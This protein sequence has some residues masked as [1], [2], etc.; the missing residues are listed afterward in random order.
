MALKLIVAVAIA[1]LYVLLDRGLAPFLGKRSPATI[2][3]WAAGLLLLTFAVR[4]N[5][6]FRLPEG[7][8][9]VIGLFS[10]VLAVNLLIARY[11]GYRPAG[12]LNRFNFAVVYPVF[13]EIAFRGLILPLLAE[14]AF[15]AKT[16]RIPGIGELNG[17]ILLTAFL[18][19]VSHLQYYRL[20][21]QS[22]V[23]MAFAFSEAAVFYSQGNGGNREHG[24]NAQDT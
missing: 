21:R 23:F 14:A 4:G 7:T 2:Y 24:K 15:L 16:V 10:A 20:N 5:Y 6:V 12:A 13:E 19:A 18:F 11:S 17:A 9:S 1:F 8:G 3:V 22:I